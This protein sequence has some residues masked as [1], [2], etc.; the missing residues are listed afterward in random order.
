MYGWI[1]GQLHMRYPCGVGH[2]GAVRECWHEG[3][4]HEYLYMYMLPI[5]CRY[6]NHD[7]DKLRMSSIRLVIY[8]ERRNLCHTTGADPVSPKLFGSCFVLWG[9]IGRACIMAYLSMIDSL[10]CGPVFQ[11][12]HLRM[13]L[14]SCTGFIMTSCFIAR[15][16]FVFR[17]T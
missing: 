14:T 11:V 6:A 13:W 16:S 1:C 10:A 4:S 2:M 7:Y 5:L 8:R 9:C 3:S 15:L 17:Q 12:V